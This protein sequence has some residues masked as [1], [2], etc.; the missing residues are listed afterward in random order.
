MSSRKEY[1]AQYR[2]E[3]REEIN[4]K[5][6]IYAF[7]VRRKKGLK[8]R[9]GYT[10]PEPR[11]KLPKKQ[12]SISYKRIK[13]DKQKSCLDYLKNAPISEGEKKIARERFNNRYHYA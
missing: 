5:N 1:Y 4:K 10:V 3:N 12:K 6:R 7:F 8:M 11:K 2:K 9:D 13:H